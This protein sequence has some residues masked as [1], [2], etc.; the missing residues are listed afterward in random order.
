[1]CCSALRCVAASCKT[2]NRCMF[3]FIEC[4]YPVSLLAMGYPDFCDGDHLSTHCNSLQLTATHCNS[5]LLTATH[6][7]SRQLTATHCNSLKTTATHCNCKK[8]ASF[9]PSC[10]LS[11]TS[12]YIYAN[13]QLYAVYRRSTKPV[14]PSRECLVDGASLECIVQ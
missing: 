10:S 14:F 3:D 7:N 1:M 12:T 8:S 11:A 6:C 5:L 13:R 2:L 9:R 4:P